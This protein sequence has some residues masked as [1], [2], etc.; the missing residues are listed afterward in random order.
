MDRGNREGRKE[1]LDKTLKG[2]PIGLR[3]QERP[4]HR[5]I[6]YP[7]QKARWRRGEAGVPAAVHGRVSG[8]W[9]LGSSGNGKEQRD[10]KKTG[11]GDKSALNE[12]DRAGDA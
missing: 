11:K 7:V 1:G 12:G 3:R 6:I 2:Q 5:R 4:A 10:M 9:L 8:A